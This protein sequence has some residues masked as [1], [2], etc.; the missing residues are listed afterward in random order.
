MM[1]LPQHLR[2]YIVE[3]NY[4]KYTPRDHAVWRYVLRQL[5]NFLKK[6][7]DLLIKGTLNN[8]Y[9]TDNKSLLPA[10]NK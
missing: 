7:P 4:D 6:V 8:E 5:K 2:K 3:Q 10:I 1:E 9:L